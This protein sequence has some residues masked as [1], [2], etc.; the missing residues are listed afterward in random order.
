MPIINL[1]K[2]YYPLVKQDVF[3]EVSDEVA[4]ALLA[5]RR[6]EDRIR[7]R[8]RY[9]KAYY[10]LDASEGME[11]H[12]LNLESKSPEDAL[13]QKEDEA[14]QALMVMRLEKAMQ[15]LTPIQARRIRARFFGKKKF[16]EIAEAEGIN[17]SQASDSI[18]RAMKK[19]RKYFC[20]N[21]WELW[22]D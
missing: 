8:I 10:S 22:E 19:M 6:D 9:H 21:N 1:R 5:L 18:H 2:Y 3:I 16:R 15:I 4:E 14:H 11:N 7:S 17:T 13:I 12:T 20:K